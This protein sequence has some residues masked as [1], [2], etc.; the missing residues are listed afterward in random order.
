MMEKA[1]QVHFCLL[2]NSLVEERNRGSE[3]SSADLIK[4]TFRWKK[5][6]SAGET[7]QSQPKKTVPTYFTWRKRNI[8]S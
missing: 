5:K 4:I 3:S 8:G 2:F 7:Q 1:K 6:P